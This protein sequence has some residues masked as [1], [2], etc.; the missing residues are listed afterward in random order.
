MQGR[1]TWQQRLSRRDFSLTMGLFALQWA[2]PV[3]ARAAEPSSLDE[4]F[5]FLSKH[6]NST[7][8]AA[9]TE[10][11]TKMPVT[12]RLQGS[13]CAPMDRH[14]YGEQVEALKK[15]AVILEIPPDPYDIAAGTAQKVM[16]FYDLALSPDEQRAYQHAMDNSDERG[17]CCCQ[18]WRWRV[19][20]GLG[21][22][23][24]REHRFTGERLV[25][26]WNLSSGCGGGAEHRHE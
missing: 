4:R 15:Y 23:L 16:R 13:C 22:L 26:V 9:F 19:Y 3:A 11:I 24:I 1:L 21:K 8:S 20:G 18:C 17:P 25:D 5:D 6:G 2:I 14:H 10:S 12:A 7:C